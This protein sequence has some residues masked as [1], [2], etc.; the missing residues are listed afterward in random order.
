MRPEDLERYAKEALADGPSGLVEIPAEAALVL[1]KHFRSALERKD[2]EIAAW[3][4]AEED[5]D[6]EMQALEARASQ[7]EETLNRIWERLDRI[8]ALLAGAI[9]TP[10]VT[11]DGELERLLE[12]KREAQA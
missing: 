1:V 2:R 3:E 11:L 8:T 10:Q 5:Q 9:T 7:A 4:E 12:L 6:E